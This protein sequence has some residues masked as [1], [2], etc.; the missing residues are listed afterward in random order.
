MKYKASY[1]Q[2]ETKNL[3]LLSETGGKL[4]EN[5]KAFVGGVEGTGDLHCVIRRSGNG[6]R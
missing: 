4:F 1:E 5:I 3:A 6:I 2:A